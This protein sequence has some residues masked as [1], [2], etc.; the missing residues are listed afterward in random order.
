LGEAGNP[1]PRSTPLPSKQYERLRP[2][3]GRGRGARSEGERRRPSAGGENRGEGRPVHRS[4]DTRPKGTV[5]FKWW[6]RGR[7]CKYFGGGRARSEG[8][9]ASG[10]IVR[11][12]ADEE[13]RIAELGRGGSRE[14]AVLRPVL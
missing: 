9:G 10:G 14:E 13:V 5:N 2:K 8:R 1:R 11:Q 4:H 12:V 3:E 7:R 6:R